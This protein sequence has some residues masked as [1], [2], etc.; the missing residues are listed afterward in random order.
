MNGILVIDKEKNMTSRDVVNQI[1]RLFEESKVGHAGT[2]DPNATGVL[3][4]AI[5]NATKIIELLSDDDK[6]YIGEVILGI[7]TDTLDIT[8]NIIEKCKVT[9]IDIKKLKE[10]LNSFKGKIKQEVPLYSAVKVNGKRL[11]QYARGNEKVTL[12]IK[13]VNIKEIQIISDIKHLDNTIRFNIRCVVSKGTYIRS[14]IKDI[15]LKLNLP[16]CMGDLRRIRQGNITIKDAFKLDNI[17]NYKLLKIEALLSN[18]EKIIVDKNLEEQIRHG[19]V[20]DKFFK[21]DIALIFNKE[22]ELIAIYEIYKKDKLLVKPKI[23]F[24]PSNN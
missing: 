21:N 19:R 1:N 23:V 2:L 9:D 14:L 22:K 10:V 24:M 6:E 20:L 13:E 5:G 12:P 7:S 3:L 18:Y 17:I 8:G 4:I 16:S 15:G 11:Y